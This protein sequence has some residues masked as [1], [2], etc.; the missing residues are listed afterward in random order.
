[1]SAQ[2]L[3]AQATGEATADTPILQVLELTRC[4]LPHPGHLVLVDIMLPK[5]N[6]HERGRHLGA[7]CPD[8][9]IIYMSAYRSGDIFRR[10]FCRSRSQ[11]TR[12]SR[13][14]GR[15]SG[16]MRRPRS[17]KTKRPAKR[18]EASVFDTLI[19]E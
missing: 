11:A 8:T 14:S 5:P 7:V 18:H 13:R 6:G 10:C 16:V 12:P 17:P 1:M 9:P 3:E 19:P 2:R 4:A 15:V